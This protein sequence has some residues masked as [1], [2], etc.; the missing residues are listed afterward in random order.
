MTR[1]GLSRRLKPIPI[2]MLIVGVGP[3]IGLDFLWNVL[4][5]VLRVSPE[6]VGGLDYLATFLLVGGAIWVA[7]RLTGETTPR[8]LHST[9][10]FNFSL[11]PLLIGATSCALVLPLYVWVLP[12]RGIPTA[13]PSWYS[14]PRAAWVLTVVCIREELIY[15]GVLFRL[16]RQGRSF[17]FAGTV[18]AVVFAIAHSHV[19]SQDWELY[20][21]DMSGTSAL[22]VI[23]FVWSFALCVLY[24]RGRCAL[25]ACVLLHLA[26][27]SQLLFGIDLPQGKPLDPVFMDGA[28]AHKLL[29]P[30]LVMPVCWLVLPGRQ[31]KGAEA[32]QP[33]GKR[34]GRGTQVRS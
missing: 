29:L 12:S 6:M 2:K 25:W 8:V 21:G 28:L 1:R 22:M 20:S 5:N 3:I 33:G 16:L 10:V 7:G 17:S 9:G 32:H 19:L 24:E 15:R 30:L 4:G 31:K 23:W 11:A 13:L 18:A 26:I 14:V 27:V 34:E